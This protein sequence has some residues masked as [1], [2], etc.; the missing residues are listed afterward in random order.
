M[1]RHIKDRYGN[2]VFLFLIVSFIFVS[3]YADN[4]LNAQDLNPPYPR[5]GIFTFSGQTEACVDILKDFDII[6]YPP[7][8][9][10]AY[11]YKAANPSVILLATSDCLIDFNRGHTLGDLPEEWY[12]HDINGNRFEIWNNAHI[13]NIT[14]L[15]PKVDLGDGNGPQTYIDY[16][17][18]FLQQDIDFS[19]YDGVF[20]DWWW[21]GPGYNVR[22]TGD[23]NGN[24]VADSQEWGADS[25]QTLW[26]MGLKD[27][28]KR[29]YQIPGVKY[30][31]VQ[32]GGKGWDLW[33]NI[34]GA[35]FE[36][37]P[38][39]NGP[40]KGW[41]RNYNDTKTNTKE[42]KI[43]LFNSSH[44]FYN[45][46][47][48]VTPYKNN[49]RSVR[50]GFTSCLLTSSYFYVD[51]GNQIGHHGNIYFYDEFE[52]KGQL[53]YP[54]TDMLKIEGKP[55]AATPYADGVWVRFFDN[56]V[57][58]VNASGVEQTVTASDLSALD[59]VA[60]SRYYRFQGG[61]D[62]VFNNG[63]EVT[64]T[65]PLILWGDAAK[66]NWAEDEVFGDGI[67]LFRNK[68]TFLTPIV[69]DNN[70]DNQTSPG[71]D[72]ASYTGGWVMSTDGRK[73]Y[74][75]YDN[76]DYGPYQK[77]GFAWAAPGTGE[78][79]ASYVPTIGLAGR[80][81]VYEWHGYIGSDPSSQQLSNHVPF[82]IND[83]GTG[84]DTTIYVDQTTNFGRWNSLGIFPFSK[85][86]ESLIKITNNT[87]GVV[88]SD[89]VKF[90]YRGPLGNS[91]ITP[92]N[93]PTGVKVI[94]LE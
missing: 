34:N 28:H 90:V 47:F 25:V 87:S 27:F 80:Y 91:D 45:R 57:S 50:Y 22:T 40:W 24:G 35:C 64:D 23:L 79:I 74:A 55:V 32:I 38:I 92:P 51:E 41:R 4:L 14:P 9:A 8:N 62:P 93:A 17:I 52:T 12:W 61:Q 68:K 94:R 69:V 78:E 33:P 58:V 82:I 3:S 7:G 20:H 6:A 59:P 86:K 81:E 46:N 11:D 85:G 44:S 75:V 1:Y 21:I 16:I 5:L 26:E 39:Y 88:I 72:P 2:K 70:Q 31:V 36:D 89:A 42:P 71:S 84:V 56:G 15:C 53:G 19:V 77:Y 43:M 18:R 76:R 48:P 49:Y 37:W 66:A 73:F 83:A 65:N 29:E 10:R 60:G 63:E 54:R 67:I 30:V 13:M